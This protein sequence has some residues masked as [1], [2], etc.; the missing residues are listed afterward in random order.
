MTLKEEGRR[1]HMEEMKTHTC[2]ETGKSR[3]RSARVQHTSCSSSSRM[4]MLTVSI[5]YHA[6]KDSVCLCFCTSRHLRQY[7]R[8]EVGMRVPFFQTLCLLD[9]MNVTVS[10][11]VAVAVQKLRRMCILEVTLDTL[12][13]PSNN[14]ASSHTRPRKS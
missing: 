6:K 1:E 13:Q 14:L 7:F 5:H 3:S 4:L 2:K 8:T 12:S 9:V 10:S 11:D